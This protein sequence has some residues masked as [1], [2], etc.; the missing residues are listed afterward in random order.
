MAAKKK[1]TAVVEKAEAVLRMSSYGIEEPTLQMVVRTNDLT[2]GPR[3]G[4]AVGLRA[5]SEI[6]MALAE[7]NDTGWLVNAPA[8]G[9]EQRLSVGW[10]LRFSIGLEGCRGAKAEVAMAV[11]TKVAYALAGKGG[12]R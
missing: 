6:E 8:W 12:S 7:A 10:R 11:L 5:A 2:R 3:Y 4:H 1:A 9:D